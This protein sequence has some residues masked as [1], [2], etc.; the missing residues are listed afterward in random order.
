M[1]IGGSPISLHAQ[2]DVKGSS[3]HPLFPNRMP[4][5][6]ISNYQQQGFSSYKFRTRPP[7]TIEGKYTR[8]HYYLIDTKQHPGGLAIRR[9]YENAIKSAGGQV[10]YS[11]DNVSVMKA[12]RNGVEVYAEV[13]ASANYAGR[14]YFLHIIEREPMQQVITADAMAAA[15][16]KDGFV[17]LDIRF[18]TGKAEILPESRPIVGEIVTLLKQ[19]SGLRVGVEGHTDNTGT[20]AGNK[21]LSD[22]RARAV[23]AAIAAAGIDPGRLDPVGFG[24]ERPIADNRTEDGRAKNRRVE[25]VKR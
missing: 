23:A 19:R 5:Y 11:D 15:I 22:A 6:S 21:T 25:I 3:D 16:D 7:R 18:A 13:Q 12:T 4:G 20:A 10:I 24:Q 14:Y 9:N 2:Q 1:I 8:I 17:A